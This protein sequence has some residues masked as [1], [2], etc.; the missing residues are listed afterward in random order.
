MDL[1]KEVQNVENIKVVIFDF[2]DTLYRGNCWENWGKHVK[3]FMLSVFKNEQ[4][5]EE[6]MTK[7]NIDYRSNGS[8]I[9][10]ATIE[11]IGSAKKFLEYENTHIYQH[12]YARLQ[13]IQDYE[14][15]ALAKCYPLYIVSNSVIKYIKYH[16]KNMGINKKHFKKIYQNDFLVE[17][18]TKTIAYKDILKR[19]KAEPN[20]VVVIGDSY[21]NDIEPALKLKMQG[22][23]VQ[24]L[25]ETREAIMFLTK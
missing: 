14:I 6:V 13:V 24:S 12:D 17:D 16:L 25:D 15:A 8:V 3:E 2:D 19:E 1:T 7:Y 20:Q 4:K 10:K 23:W 22:I 5:V 11:E 21:T 9:A 18:M